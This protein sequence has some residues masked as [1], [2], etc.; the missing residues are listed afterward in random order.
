MRCGT[1]SQDC[2][3]LFLLA[4]RIGTI[5][6]S[7]YPGICNPAH[8]DSRTLLVLCFRFDLCE[9]MTTTTPATSGKLTRVVAGPDLQFLS[10]IRKQG[11]FISHPVLVFAFLQIDRLHLLIMGFEH[12]IVSQAPGFSRL[13]E[14]QEGFAFV[15]FGV[16]GSSISIIA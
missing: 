15:F 5:S 2:F 7:S 1:G 3:R 4:L 11:E 10:P 9:S 12:L 14:Q 6:F 16:F 8:P 13:H